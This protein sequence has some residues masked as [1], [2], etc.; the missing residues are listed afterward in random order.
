MRVYHEL[1]R[2]LETLQDEDISVI[3]LK[4]A[5]LAE[6]VYGNI[7]L[8]PMSDVDLLVKE[9]DLSRVEKKL[10]AMGYTPDEKNTAELAERCVHFTYKLPREGLCMEIHWNIQLSN[11]PFNVDVDGLWKRTRPAMIAGVRVLALSPE[12]LLLHLCLHTAFRHLFGQSAL[13]SL[14]DISE[15]IRHYQDQIDWE[16]V[17]HRA[18][19]WGIGNCLHL[20]LHLASKL[21][22]A[23][24]PG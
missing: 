21:L 9:P 15:T 14:C 10:L 2:V 12:D 24:V 6:V 19:Q 4:G 16:Q 22:G 20:T 23:A 18:H 11:S 1:A 17:R 8:R 5:H 3:A 7:A 13:R